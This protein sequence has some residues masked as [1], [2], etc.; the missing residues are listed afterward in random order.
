M[1]NPIYVFAVCFAMFTISSCRNERKSEAN[2][3]E[4]SKYT[5]DSTYHLFGDAGKPAINIHLSMHYPVKYKNSAVL[6]SLQRLVITEVTS[7]SNQT[8]RNPEEAMRNFIAQQ[9]AEYR[10]LEKDYETILSM[11]YGEYNVTP[12]SFANQYTGE[13]DNV[14]DKDGILCFSNNVFRYTG[15]AHGVESVKYMCVDLD[16]GTIITGKDLFVD[17]YEAIL[18]PIILERLAQKQKVNSPKELEKNGFFDISDI[19]PNNN[20]YLNEKGITY[21]YNPY[22]IAAYFV[23]ISEVFIPY[24]DIDFILAKQSPVKRIASK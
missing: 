13:E 24:E 3:I 4:F 14:F 21:V 23:G 18:S 5:V 20:F 16:N 15:G 17:N 10:L 19:K 11:R 12:T 8:L 6:D 2:N 22:E 1:K 7:N 9:I